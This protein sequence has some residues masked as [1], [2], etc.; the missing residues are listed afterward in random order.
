MA[1]QLTDNV[2]IRLPKQVTFQFLTKCQ[3]DGASQHPVII[4]MF[5]NKRHER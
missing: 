3:S 2:W 1:K 5:Q 4:P